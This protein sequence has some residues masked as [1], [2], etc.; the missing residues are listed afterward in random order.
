MAYGRV[1]FIVEWGLGSSST[2]GAEDMEALAYLDQSVG[3]LAE[4]VGASSDVS[5]LLMDTHAAVNGAAPEDYKA[6]ASDIRQSAGCFGFETSLLSD[7]LRQS[8]GLTIEDV[9]AHSQCFEP[10][11]AELSEYSRQE[12]SRRAASHSVRHAAEHAARLYFCV[13]RLEGTI[14]TAIFAGGI[15]ITYQTPN[16]SFLLPSLPTVF[17]FVA[18]GRVTKRPWFRRDGVVR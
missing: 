5:L 14:L 12:L 7:F 8:D 11:W 18:A 17:T 1:R 10:E 3:I 2:F 16:F 15:L 9:I 4:A 6:Y 13:S